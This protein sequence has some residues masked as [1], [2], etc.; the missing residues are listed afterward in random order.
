MESRIAL[1]AIFRHQFDQ[2]VVNRTSQ[3]GPK[4]NLTNV[5]FRV[6]FQGQS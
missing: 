5:R 2:G 1:S 4:A 3:S 6:G